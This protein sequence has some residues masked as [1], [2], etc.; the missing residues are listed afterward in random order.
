MFLF[1]KKIMI[2]II[3]LIGL[4]PI[5]WFLIK[6]L[7]I[8]LDIFKLNN[9]LDLDRSN[10]FNNFD[11]NS[12]VGL[13]VIDM[14]R[15][16]LEAHIFRQLKEFLERKNSYL[17]NESARRESELRKENNSIKKDQISKKVTSENI[18]KR[19]ERLEWMVS[20]TEQWIQKQ[21][22]ELSLH[23]SQ[24]YLFI[25]KKFKE[26]IKNIG[27][28]YKIRMIIESSPILYSE[29]IDLTQVVLKEFNKELKN[30]KIS[31]FVKE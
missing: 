16:K 2:N 14:N 5:A 8:N 20:D 4:V 21:K 3:F 27:E 17:Y 22:E 7:G 18:L 23:A 9:I 19:K 11:E 28:K 24:I 6:P 29:G 1:I 25:E 12:L 31:D 10:N 30:F 26:V 15:I 13:G